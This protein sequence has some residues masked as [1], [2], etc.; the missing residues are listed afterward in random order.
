MEAGGR[1]DYV[2]LRRSVDDYLSLSPP[3]AQ[4]VQ[5]RDLLSLFVQADEDVSEEEALILSELGGL[6]GEYL[7]DEDAVRY[8]VLI[9]P[10]SPEQDRAISTLFPQLTRCDI[11]GGVAFIAGTFYSAEYAEMIADRYRSLRFFCSVSEARENGAAPVA[12]RLSPE[13]QAIRDAFFQGLTL[14]E[15]QELRQ[16]AE[17]RPVAAGQPLTREGHPLDTLLFVLEGRAD[18]VLGDETIDQVDAGAFVGELEYVSGRPSRATVT[19]SSD[20]RVLAWST[21]ALH[22]LLAQRPGIS[23]VL[24]KIL[25]ADLVHKLQMGPLAAA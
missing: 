25:S 19:A 13:D 11:A 3:L 16:V 10:Q 15:F 9:V 21:H 22:D 1:T 2:R 8:Q 18:V 5:L 14:G 4:V 6:F 23:L 20:L 7:E 24:Q 17:L 12:I